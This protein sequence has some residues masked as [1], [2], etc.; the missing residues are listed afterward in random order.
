METPTKRLRRV[1]GQVAETSPAKSARSQNDSAQEL[2]TAELSCPICEEAMVTLLQLNRHIDDMH[3]SGS[4]SS[5]PAPPR[6]PTK[7][8]IKLDLYDGNLGFGLS[9]S[10]GSDNIPDLPGH[11]KLTRSHWKL[12]NTTKPSYCSHKDCKKQLN[13][14][15]GVV[16]CR[17]CGKLFCN[18]H[19]TYKVRLSNGPQ[20]QKLPIYDSVNGAFARACE[21]CFLSR[22]ALVE[23]TQANLR[24]V[25]DTFRKKRSEHIEEKKWEKLK[26]QRRFLKLVTLLL[27]CY[28]WHVDLSQSVFLYFADKG[29]YSTEKMLE[30]EKEVVGVENWQ[31]DAE[32]THCPLCF[33]KFNF[34]IRKHHCRLCGQVVS[35]TAFN[36]D[37]PRMSCSLQ[38][39]V[40][41]VL[42]K[43]P[44][45]NYAPQVKDRWL[46]LINVSADSKHANLF[47]FR[48]CREC[49]DT[50]FHGAKAD[51]DEDGENEA[52]L[53]ACGEML[54]IKANIQHAMPRYAQLINENK[55]TSNHDINKLR[56]RI[57]KSVK[58]FEITTN[59]FRLRFFRL[60]PETNKITPTQSP[61]LVG[62]I[63][64]MAV[65]FLQ[66]SILEFKRLSDQFQS[67]ENARLSGQLGL[68]PNSETSVSASPMS[69]I[70]SPPPKP[71]LTKKQIREFRE[72]LMVVTEQNF[73][74]QK[75]MEDA[76][77]QR[78][79]DEL[80]VLAS[81]S[82]ELQKHIDELHEQLGEFGFA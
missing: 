27:Q 82:D 5:S 78:K 2:A 33:V 31:N 45:L 46:E 30:A 66:E 68:T 42:R 52:I 17:K 74:V 34:L 54:A 4:E 23:G 58:D 21:S 26:L 9:D 75:Q 51:S 14:K 57:R 40:S 79:F 3:G 20:P 71:R 43:L 72:Q 49:K 47:S 12:P 48:C 11:H 44:G 25:T 38:V 62:N 80:Q 41:L 76:K 24:D 36:T 7:R 39:P 73:L 65:M 64:K 60:N 18:Q 13:V 53:S 16:N 10:L 15:N 55:E 81:N 69:P 32:I 8:S 61:V 50:L 67:V 63:H 35:D 77:K 28:L 19:T 37:D 29:P 56:V 22:P 59:T 1:I 70:N 6:T